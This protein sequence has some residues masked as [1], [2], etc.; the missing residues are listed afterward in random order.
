MI[1]MMYEYD[2]D[3]DKGLDK[4]GGCMEDGGIARCT[5]LA[6]GKEQGHKGVKNTILWWYPV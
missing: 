3:W 1:S 5:I 6:S 4:H 2:N